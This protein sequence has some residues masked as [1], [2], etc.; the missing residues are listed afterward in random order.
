M[1]QRKAAPKPIG[2]AAFAKLCG[3]S[4]PTMKEHLKDAP[5]D[6]SWLQRGRL[7]QSYRIVPGPGKDWFEARRAAIGSTITAEQWNKAEVR[8]HMAGA[9]FK[10]ED[11]ILPGK[12]RAEEYKALREEIAYR[13]ELGDVAP[14][15]EVEQLLA[16]VMVRMS[17]AL[18]DMPGALRRKFNL[19]REVETWLYD[20]MAAQLKLANDRLQAAYSQPDY[21]PA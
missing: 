16:D 9:D 19:D 11:L 5:Q 12:R 4:V 15:A 6:T 18:R 17:K 21:Q 3:V 10:P 1:S 8:A 2:L 13:K 14:V 7:G 20:Q